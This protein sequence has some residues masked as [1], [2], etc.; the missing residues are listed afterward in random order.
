MAHILFVDLATPDVLALR[1][2]TELLTA[3]PTR[4]FAPQTTV[5]VADAILL[6]SAAPTNG[7][8]VAVLQQCIAGTAGTQEDLDLAQAACFPQLKRACRRWAA[9]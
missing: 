7:V 8:A 6:E 4:G 3:L 5:T 2:K 1:E 9:R